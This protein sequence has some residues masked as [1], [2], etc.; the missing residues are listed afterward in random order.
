MTVP[1]PVADETKR[2]GPDRAP[3]RSSL[4]QSIADRLGSAR[5]ARWIVE[6]AGGD[7]DRAL[8]LTGRRAAGEPLQY[9]LGRWPFRTLELTV[10]R[11]V[12]IPR[13]ETEHVVEV[14]LAG[15]MPFADGR[16]P[17]RP[18][19]GPV[20]V[21]LGTGSGAIALALA[22]EG[23]DRF[24]G[25]E[26]WATDLSP[27]AL[28]VAR[29]NTTEL[30]GRDADAASRVHLS[31]GPWFDALPPDL[32]GQVDLVVSNPPYVAEDDYPGLD[33]E[34][35]RWE[36]RRALVAGL[37]SDGVGGMAAIESVVAGARRWLRPSGLLVVEIDPRQAAAS[38]GAARRAGF[39]DVRVER[40]LAGRLRVLVAR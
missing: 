11:R 18:D 9:V 1:G 13:P 31:E 27:E 20:C 28:T 36:P 40:D 33:P 34:V 22:V 17:G 29:S 37:G 4:E 30:G 8:A 38:I 10:D 32:V 14:A 39:D 24:P 7:H 21:D 23:G 12:L 15:L 35:R 2:V 16:T 26:V 3:D 19:S 5:E 6:H 25:L